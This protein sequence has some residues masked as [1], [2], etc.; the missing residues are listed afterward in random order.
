MKNDLSVEAG[1][2][3]K[4]LDLYLSENIEG[5]SRTR[6]QK[7]IEA[8]QILVNGAPCIDNNYRV[9]ENDEINISVPPPEKATVEPEN[10]R[11]DII[12]ED[13]DLLVVNK[14]RGM[15]VHPGPG[16]SGGTLVNALLYYCQ[17]LSGIGGIM[18]PG[19]VH[20]LDKDT[21]GLLIVAKNDYTHSMLSAALKSRQM[22]REYLA[23]VH[24]KVVPRFG[25]I[26]VPVGRH[27]RHRKKMAVVQGGREA[28][29]SYSVLKYY[30]RHSL[31][32][33]K[34]QTGRTHQIRV[35]L[36]YLGYPV[37]GDLTY[38]TASLSD[39]P[40]ELAA[41]HALHARRIVFNHP[42]SG[43]QLE[44]SAPLPADFREGLR[45]LKARG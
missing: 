38:S 16:H 24:G 17:D 6:L 32:R 2:A 23:L 40:E 29:T 42:R 21:S 13:K 33:L 5:L 1:Q 31:L 19:I 18:R 20:R 36:A 14:P 39:L 15:V 37:V 4:R 22:R 26:D 44:F 45:Q 43:K 28:V 27:P 9:Q 34:L 7:L 10:I 25:K 35:H 30:E 3:G 8:G 41:P 11:L 12:F